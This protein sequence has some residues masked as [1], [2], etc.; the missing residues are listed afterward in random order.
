MEADGGN[1]V[2]RHLI[3]SCQW[4]ESICSDDCHKYKSLQLLQSEGAK[5]IVLAHSCMQNNQFAS[6]EFN[7]VMQ[8]LN[9]TL[10]TWWSSIKILL[11][12][13]EKKR[14]KDGSTIVQNAVQG[15]L[16]FE[17]LM[18]NALNE[19][20][21]K[22]AKWAAFVP[23][24]NMGR[25]IE[26]FLHEETD[27]VSCLFEARNV[28]EGDK[29]LLCLQIVAK[30]AFIFVEHLEGLCSKHIPI[31]RFVGAPQRLRVFL[32]IDRMELECTMNAH[33]KCFVTNN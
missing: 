11:S 9:S 15:D 30:K 5:A 7:R 13:V 19:D 17:T 27:T 20:F 14:E 1:N 32:K 18:K 24:L 16:H 2:R 8:L 10:P 3:K 4:V 23:Q 26:L 33:W 6:V 29:I 12:I 31:N 25:E 28:K 22:T 21:R